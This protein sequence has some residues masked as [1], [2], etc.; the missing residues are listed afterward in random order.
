MREAPARGM[1]ARVAGTHEFRLL[2]V[3]AVLVLGLALGTRSFFTVR[4]LFDLLTSYAFTGIL[5]AGLLVV[6]IAGGIDISFTATASVAQYVAVSAALAY[7][8]GWAGLFALAIAVG[9][10]LGLV[11]AVLV[12]KLRISSII[13]TIA[14]LN[15]FYGLLVFATHGNYIYALPDWFGQGFSWP[16]WH[17]ADGTAY[18][19]NLQILLLVIAFA[20][21][22]V[23]LAHTSTGRQIYALGGNP[24]AAQRAGFNVFRLNLLVYGLMGIMAGIASLAEAQLDQS[25]MPT[26]LVGKELHVLA[27]VVLG[28]ASLLGGVGSVPGAILGV[29]LLAVMENGL[30]ILGV[31]SYWLDFFVGLVILVA[32]SST[33]VELLGRRTRRAAA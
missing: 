24:D 27:A 17:G 8:I 22:W 9:L 12:S 5:A 6:L 4:N 21:V 11:N 31:P 20:L 29:A 33:T 19:V 32:V 23:L 7:P 18:A 3:V 15:V 30:I 25:V 1:L 26:A 10:A 16:V 28:G 14:T 2:V 13:I